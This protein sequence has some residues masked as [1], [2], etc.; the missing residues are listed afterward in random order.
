MSI[1][2]DRTSRL[3]RAS[4]R[5]S[6]SEGT[7]R[8]EAEFSK[9]RE[10]LLIERVGAYRE[11]LAAW[12]SE[13]FKQAIHAEDFMEEIASGVKLC[14]LAKI[15]EDGEADPRRR[16]QQFASRSTG[17]AKPAPVNYSARPS[18]QYA[19]RDNVTQF[20]EWAKSLGVSEA[21]LFEADDLVGKH[22][23]LNCEKNVLYS[24]MEL[25]RVQGGVAPPLLVEIERAIDKGSYFGGISREQELGMEHDMEMLLAKHQLEGMDP[26]KMED[27]TYQFGA[28]GPFKVAELR[29][30]LMVRLANSWD[31]L[32][33]VL[34]ST[35]P[36]NKPM[37]RRRNS[38]VQDTAEDHNRRASVAD[39][40]LQEKLAPQKEENE[41]LKLQ[42][43]SMEEQLRSARDE[44]AR[45]GRDNELKTRD[46]EQLETRSREL[47]VELQEQSEDVMAQAQ[48]NNRL[49]QLEDE[50][51]ALRRRVDDGAVLQDQLDTTKQQLALAQSERDRNAAGQQ[52]SDQALRDQIR[53]LLEKLNTANENITRLQLAQERQEAEYKRLLLERSAQAN[54]D[55]AKME[56][57]HEQEIEDLEDEIRNLTDRNARLLQEHTTTLGAQAQARLAEAE[58]EHARQQARAAG[59]L[60]TV[61]ARLEAEER[62]RRTLAEQE[63]TQQREL[64]EAKQ[65]LAASQAAQGSH[66]A[67]QEELRRLQAIIDKLK[68][69]HLKEA[70]ET[71]AKHLQAM[72]ELQSK[73]ADADAAVLTGKQASTEKDRQLREA[74]EAARQA[75]LKLSS[76]QGTVSGVE[77]QLATARERTQR[78]E[79]EA[80][81]L[82]AQLAEARRKARQLEADLLSS[83]HGQG[84]MERKL[85][86]AQAG[87]AREA[88]ERGALQARELEL[89]AALRQQQALVSGLQGDLEREKATSDRSASLGDNARIAALEDEIARLKAELAVAQQAL[90][91][92]RK[93]NSDLHAQLL[94][95]ETQQTQL[96]IKVQQ[97]DLKMTEKDEAMEDLKSNH[98][99]DMTKL[100]HKNE[101]LEHELERA[102]R[103]L[104]GMKINR[105]SERDRLAAEMA[106]QRAQ[107]QAAQ[108]ALSDLQATSDP[109]AGDRL[110][111]T[112]ARLTEVEG[113]FK[114]QRERYE[115][116]IKQL[117]MRCM[118]AERNETAN[119]LE[120]DRLDLKLNGTRSDAEQLKAQLAALQA[121]MDAI[122]TGAPS[123]LNKR[124]ADM[125]LH[126]LTERDVADLSLHDD[127]TRLAHRRRLEARLELAEATEAANLAQAAYDAQRDGAN[128]RAVA[129]AQE[130]RRLAVAEVE[131][132]QRDFEHQAQMALDRLRM[133]ERARELEEA[134]PEMVRV[135]SRENV[136]DKTAEAQK[137]IV[138]L[139]HRLKVMST[140]LETAVPAN[141]TDVSDNSDRNELKYQTQI[142]YMKEQ[143]AKDRARIEGL[144]QQLRTAAVDA[145]RQRNEAEEQ[146]RQ[147]ENAARL[148]AEM[149]RANAVD[150]LIG[151]KEE[152]A[153]WINEL[154]ETDLEGKDLLDDLKSGVILCQVANVVDE[155]EEQLRHDEDEV[156]P[157]EEVVVDEQ[158][159]DIT[160]AVRERELMEVQFLEPAPP[161]SK[162]AKS[163]IRA[164][165][166]WARGLGLERPDVFATPDLTHD[167]DPEKVLEGMLRVARRT[168][169]LPLPDSV[170]RE[171]APF[172]PERK[173][174]RQPKYRQVKGDEVDE[175]VAE[176][177]NFVPQMKTKLKRVAKGKYRLAEEQKLLLMRVLRDRVLVRVGGGWEE[178]QAFLEHK[179][180]FGRHRNQ[181]PNRVVQDVLLS[182]P[183]PGLCSTRTKMPQRQ[184]R[185]QVLGRDYY[186]N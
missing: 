160:A 94:E 117:R 66:S 100:T 46:L 17:R 175:R 13:L 119:R 25:G 134:D 104:D 113:R 68:A 34:L 127:P 133:V 132:S 27:G 71:H 44:I 76:Q 99:S 62:A 169:S 146:A 180:K 88:T 33:H 111:Q 86:E 145:A 158:G 91:A 163:N 166:E 142:D 115:D 87:L 164:F 149:E 54:Q 78:A 114:T 24:L 103:E 147:L 123:G 58:A 43:S 126:H 173:K 151:K 156:G 106:E 131:D 152:V 55:T 120:K 69:D 82:E 101:D 162:D 48:R 64:D 168:R 174:K 157:S 155:V 40:L 10:K 98:R 138:E 182:T 172:Q 73:L 70:D 105:D 122:A 53:D 77:N 15:I 18:S 49:R 81:A 37:M 74:Q 183:G 80:E 35:K 108:Q 9:L 96:E 186:G 167:M 102:R 128:A 5:V 144:E 2:P 125:D 136:L 181:D 22:S 89:T 56:E 51:T 4:S 72:S 141:G 85:T 61:K 50:N 84:E 165:I 6:M 110:A 121:E 185:Q 19:R 154:L 97:H 3:R 47:A 67:T 12:F 30:R 8:N 83:K 1:D 65:A 92:L 178:L 116:E 52:V 129:A 7:T 38:I 124:Y 23:D 29:G 41:L 28:L 42:L 170:M 14:Q 161:G 140:A 107:L 60:E 75:E 31:T 176:V 95:R 39:S 137:E 159:R 20:L 79:A 148:Q 112:Q 93:E 36:K 177:L 63:Q 139:S 59:E 179:A 45:V 184:G 150:P 21:V 130:R 171:R 16:I 109:T 153:A 90:E 57:D 118:E 143:H 32:E 26:I 11:D 135:V